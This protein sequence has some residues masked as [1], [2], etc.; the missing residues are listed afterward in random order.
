MGKC[1]V[2]VLKR[3]LNRVEGELPNCNSR[4]SSLEILEFPGTRAG[5]RAHAM[6]TF[7]L[8]LCFQYIHK[9]KEIID[10]ER[11]LYLCKRKQI[12]YVFSKKFFF[13]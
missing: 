1:S 6:S 5:N 3:V 2:L 12:H 11:G 9:V 13:L 7:P 4:E 8:F 10:S